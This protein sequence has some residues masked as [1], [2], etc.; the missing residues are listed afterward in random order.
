MYYRA[1][2]LKEAGF[3]PPTTWDEYLK[4]AKYFHGKDL[5]EDGKPDYGSC[6]SKK[7]G[8]VTCWAM[9]SIAAS[10]LQSHGTQQ[11]AFFDPETMQPL[12]KNAGFAKAAGMTPQDI[13]GKTDYEMPWKK[14]E[15]DFFIECDRTVMETNVPELGIVEPQVQ[16]DGQQYWLETS[17]VPLQDMRGDVMGIIGIF[18]NITPYKEAE[19]AAQQASQ[20]KSEFLANMS[21]ELRTPLNGILGYAQILGRSKTVPPKEKDGVNIIYQCGSHLLTLINDILD[22]SKIEARKLELHPT[23]LHRNLSGTLSPWGRCGARLC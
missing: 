10:L 21:H 8:N 6:L 4:I 19:Q 12:V 13:V 5:N 18:Q 23:P 7:P 14:E 11:G 9:W 15:A 22:L 17:K 1:D 3:N 20:A 2:L 16:A